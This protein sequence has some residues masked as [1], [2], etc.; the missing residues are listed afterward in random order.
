MTE[1]CNIAR[2]L[3]EEAS[4]QPD[5]PAIHCPERFGGSGMPS[6][7]SMNFAELAKETDVIAAG[8]VASGVGRGVRTALMVRPS[9]ELY[10]LMFA[11]FKAGA[12][13]VLIDPGI[14]RSQLK[15]CLREA[16][17]E[18]FIGIPL[19]HAAS[20]LLGWARGSIRRRVTVNGR[21][22]FWGGRT[23][24][25]LR[26]RGASIENFAMADTRPDELAAILFTSGATGVPKGVEYTHR[27]F[28]AQV[29]M[30]R[31]AFGIW[32]GEVDLPTFPPFALFDP[33]LGMTSVI[34][35]MDPTRPASA[36]PAKL[37]AAIERNGVTTMF[38][39]PALIDVLARYGENNGIKLKTLRRIIS[40]G[41]PVP[42]ETVARLMKILRPKAQ[43]FTPY[44]AT[45]CLPVCAIDGREILAVSHLT[46]EGA[47]ICVGRP[48]PEN[49]V[50]L[51]RIDD[52]EVHEISFAN[53]VPP[54]GI[55]EIVVRGPTMSERYYNRP[56]AN[57]LGKILTHDGIWHR[58]GDLG[59]FDEDGRLWYLGRKA[60][61]VET[62]N[63]QF[64]P[65][66]VE[67]IFNAHPAVRRSALVALVDRDGRRLPGVCVELL[68]GL[69]DR[70]FNVIRGELRQIG[71][72][73]AITSAI[74]HFF[75][76][77]G[78]PVDIRHNAKIDRTAL[79]AW[80]ARKHV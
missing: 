66:P 42:P 46:A 12:V 34:P 70:D 8:L 57:R 26:A 77:P 64:L 9:I 4:R 41:A 38:G 65:E 54:G 10:V 39:S 71:A 56:E 2:H 67:G 76:H 20:I 18:A 40:A 75:L 61:R 23:Y 31:S 73:H 48:L 37:V 7:R 22:W 1:T 50:Q 60:H 16:A 62:G 27:Q 19:A 13:P 58:M 78:F 14:N 35:D 59:R 32:P 80:A 53:R 72:R 68:P 55:G 51:I 49:R 6:Y 43:V 29:E 69:G 44:G 52:N 74:R 21:R 15:Q 24:A 3:G 36:D 79:T 30:I 11:L 25:Q 45:E 28:A 63:G 47:G 17:P 33:A 5:R